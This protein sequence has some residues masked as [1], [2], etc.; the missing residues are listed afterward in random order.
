MSRRATARTEANFSPDVSPGEKQTDEVEK[1]LAAHR[2]ARSVG[3]SVGDGWARLSEAADSVVNLQTLDELYHQALSAIQ[4]VLGSDSVALLL[5]NEAQDELVARASIGLGEE[6]IVDLSIHYGQ[7]MAG[8]VLATRAPMIVEDLSQITLA[9][10]TLRDQGIQSLA[11]VPLLSEK[12][13]LGVLHTG[14]RRL[15]HF[16]AA[17][18]A[19]LEILADRL[20]VAL[21]AVQLF[22]QQRRLADISA[23]LA[24]TAR[25]MAEASDLS[26]ALHRLAAAALPALGDVCLIDIIE[27]GALR[28]LVARHRDPARQALVDRLRTEYAPD[29]LG[30]HPAA[31]VVQSGQVAWSAT[32]PDDFLRATTRDDEH[33]AITKAL[34]FRSYLAVPI[35]SAVDVVGT[36]TMVSCSRSFTVRDVDFALLLAQQVGAVVGNA[37]QLDLAAR[38]SHILQAALLPRALP[39]VP[40][41]AVHSR[42]EAASQ[43]LEVG[44]DFYDVALLPDGTAWFAIGDVEGHDRGAAALMGQFRSAA[45]LLASQGKS[46]AALIDELQA[47]WAL[48]GF[49]RI[50]TAL[51]GKIEPR[52]G[53]VV[54]ASAGHY[55]PLFVGHGEAHFLPVKPVPPFGSVSKSAVEWSGTLEKGE[56]LLLFTDGLISERTLGVDRSM[57]LLLEVVLRGDPA[58]D[59]VCDRVIATRADHEDDIALLALQCL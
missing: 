2:A 43:G 49:D 59:A 40:G 48:M 34:G 14:S 20:A 15:G 18:V 53:D 11:A 42:Y 55:P 54:L 31:R 13:V 44:G 17:D 27:E 47:T 28:R 1:F 7:G 3:S 39:D 56:T 25:I 6:S 12:R 21:A 32:M 26:D 10:P 52:S 33:F 36:L 9:S 29:V 51:F 19:L 57:E 4:E 38:T 8:R 24:E 30:D 35:E 22:E 50:A 46:P 5:A 23:F 45:R 37:Q 58:M 41:M 16:S